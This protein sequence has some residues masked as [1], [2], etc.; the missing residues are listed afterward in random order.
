MEFLF[1]LSLFMLFLS[2]K[3]FK[4][5]YHY[6]SALLII[7]AIMLTA[8]IFMVF[9][10]HLMHG[11]LNM[12]L[13]ILTFSVGEAAMGLALLMSTIKLSGQDFISSNHY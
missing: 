7:E 10:S 8:I 4:V 3:F 5:Q 1:N 9:L 11:S 12:Y 2:L 6:L 13:L